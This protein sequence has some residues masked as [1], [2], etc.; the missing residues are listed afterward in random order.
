MIRASDFISDIVD[1]SHWE[2]GAVPHLAGAQRLGLKA[3][4]AKTTQGKD[5]I[6][7]SY[8]PFRDECKRLGLLFGSFHFGSGTS[9]GATQADHFLTHADPS[10]LLCLDWEWQTKDQHTHKPRFPEMT[11][12]Q[13]EQFV[14]RIHERTGRW[15]LVYCGRSWVNEIGK[16][17]ADSPLANCPLW[18]VW[19]INEKPEKALPAPWS[20]YDL[21]QYTNGNTAS[22]SK[23][24]PMKTLGLG[25]VDRSAF[26]GDVASLC[27][28][29]A[30]CGRD[31]RGPACRESA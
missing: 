11:T 10:S 22:A 18:L 19:Y 15:P 6:D 30:N 14:V 26:L 21:W 16:P 3:V 24:F 5:A 20:T 29:W 13:A 23:A 31:D 9:D 8:V 1:V 25:G 2:S 28:W 27:E 7:R 17:K 4:I 12:A